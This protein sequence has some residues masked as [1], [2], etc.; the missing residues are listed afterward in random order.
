MDL[1]NSL[2]WSGYELN[3]LHRQIR[4]INNVFRKANWENRKYALYMGLK[5]ETNIL[6]HLPVDIA[7]AVTQFV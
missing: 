2:G 3:Y 6:Y 5:E 1:G 7:K 4:Y